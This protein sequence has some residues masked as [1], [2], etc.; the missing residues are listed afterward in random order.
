MQ[1]D[2]VKELS[3]FEYLVEHARARA[4]N[5]DAEYYLH[6]LGMDAVIEDQ[7]CESSITSAKDSPITKMVKS[8]ILA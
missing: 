4:T 6:D 7:D 5:K 1:V 2:T 8:H 3:N